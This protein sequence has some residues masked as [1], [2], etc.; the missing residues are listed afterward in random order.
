[1]WKGQKLDP[2]VK[3][4]FP[5]LKYSERKGDKLNGWNNA[6]IKIYTEMNRDIKKFSTEDIDTRSNGNS[7]QVVKKKQ[8]LFEEYL[9]EVLARYRLW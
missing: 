4:G 3:N 2:K 1:M 6:G 8:K 7:S 5:K 9:V